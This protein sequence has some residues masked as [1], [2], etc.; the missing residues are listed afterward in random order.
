[1]TSRDTIDVRPVTEAELAD[2]T[3]AMNIGFL[4]GRTLPD[5]VADARPAQVTPGRT[6]G[7]FD[8]GRCVATLRSFTHE[9]T[10]VGGATVPADAVTNVTVSPTRRRRGLLS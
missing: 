6:V 4:R 10:V 1:M 9:L 7:A 8:G 2:S 3:R 5:E